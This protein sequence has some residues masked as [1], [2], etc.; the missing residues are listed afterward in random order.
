VLAKHSKSFSPIDC[1]AVGVDSMQRNFGPMRKP[2]EKWQ[3][4][5]R[6]LGS[7]SWTASLETLF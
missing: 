6:S 5:S 7:G 3:P 2:V 1:V 4:Q